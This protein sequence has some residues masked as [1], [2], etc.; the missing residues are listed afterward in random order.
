MKDKIKA[1]IWLMIASPTSEK[2]IRII[3][4][5]VATLFALYTGAHVIAALVR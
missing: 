2:A 1:L 4:I 5:A 3:C